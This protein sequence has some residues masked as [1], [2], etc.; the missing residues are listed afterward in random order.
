MPTND[1]RGTMSNTL[2]LATRLRT[3]DNDALVRTIATRELS[4]SGIKDFFDLAEAFLDRESIQQALT[5]LDRIALSGL[6]TIGELTAEG[7]PTIATVA[8]ALDRDDAWVSQQLQ[9]PAELLLVDLAGGA[10]R[11]YDPVSDQLRSWS[12]FGLPTLA[13]LLETTPPV[14]LDPVPDAEL[15]AIDRLASERAFAATTIVTELLL[16]LGREPARELAK[17]GIALPDK[18]RLANAMA[19]DLENVAAYLIVAERAELVA[20][21][22]GAWLASERGSSWLLESTQKRWRALAGGWIS[23]LAPDI[24]NLLGT[25]SHAHWGDALH[26]YVAWLYPAG[27]ERMD[28]RVTVL[29][30]HAE[31]LGITA[32]QAPSGPGALLLGGDLEGAESALLPLLPAEVEKVYL[33]HDLTVVAPG[34]LTPAV[35]ARLRVIADVENRALAATYRVSASSV[36]RALASGETASTIFSFL[37]EISLTGIPQPLE[38]LIAESSARYGLVRVAELDGAEPAEAEYGARS[39]L[40]SNDTNLLGTIVVDQSLASLNLLRVGSNRVVSRFPLDVVFWSLSD[41]RYP[42]AAENSLGAIVV[43]ERRRV[44]RTIRP[45]FADPVAELVERLRIGGEPEADQNDRDWLAKQLDAAVRGKLALTVRVRM[46]DGSTVELQLEPASVA[47]GR[48]R[49]RDR[50]SDIERTLPL[51]SIAGIGP[52]L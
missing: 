29:T 47:G 1:S 45:S 24:R 32:N 2:S 52:A 27:G 18:K 37:A 9:R 42:V 15:R 12:V 48:L 31:L 11:V 23:G 30:R 21:E 22:A 46:P 35:D 20:S 7:P 40:R 44:A 10:V 19:V 17:G 16:E 36:N 3:F 39:F 38:Y 26:S 25:R 6:A 14:D 49:A 13:E 28:E 51:S 50:K 33:Q 43:L 41:A 8:S 4:L 5:R 34:P